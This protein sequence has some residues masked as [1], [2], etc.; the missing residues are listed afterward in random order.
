MQYASIISYFIVLQ[1]AMFKMYWDPEV[2][3]RLYERD[4]EREGEREMF[5]VSN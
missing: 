1:F 4:R 3:A 5:L 2:L